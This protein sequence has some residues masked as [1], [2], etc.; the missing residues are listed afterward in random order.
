MSI[1]DVASNVLI[2]NALTSGA[3]TASFSGTGVD[4][5][6]C[7]AKGVQLLMG[8]VTANDATNYFSLAL[9]HSDDNITYVAFPESEVKTTATLVAGDK[10]ALQYDGVKRYFRL[11]GTEVGTA[12]I[13]LS[14]SG[15]CL[16]MDLPIVK[17]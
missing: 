7:V 3:Q 17:L 2:S 14:A 11:A 4:G 6:N 9:E 12:S 15:V 16:P 10:V 5:D 8:V 13:I 1:N